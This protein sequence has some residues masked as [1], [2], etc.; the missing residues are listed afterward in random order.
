MDKS[1]VPRFLLAHPVDVRLHC[2]CL[3]SLLNVVLLT[4]AEQSD[5]LLCD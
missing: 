3:D 4:T 1:K 5:F 2:H